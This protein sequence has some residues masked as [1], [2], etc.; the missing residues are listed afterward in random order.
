VV[1]R[2]PW[3]SLALLLL[4]LFLGSAAT[5]ASIALTGSAQPLKWPAIVLVSALLLSLVTLMAAWPLR[6]L[7][8]WWSYGFD[9]ATRG[10]FLR[11]TAEA[12][13]PG[14]WTLHTIHPA[15]GSS[16]LV[17]SEPYGNEQAIDAIAQWVR[18]LLA[19]NAAQ[20]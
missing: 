19:G 3:P 4:A 8:Y 10:M 18:E 14:I 2:N 15:P 16:G 13:P 7:I 9:I 12:T 17:H 6:S 11:V 1:N 20:S 5:L